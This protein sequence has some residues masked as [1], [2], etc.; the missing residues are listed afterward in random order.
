MGRIFGVN[1]TKWVAR[2]LLIAT[3]LLV[4]TLPFLEDLIESESSADAL[5]QTFQFLFPLLFTL[6]SLW[7]LT[8]LYLQVHGAER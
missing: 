5:Q 7:V 2:V 4:F 8:T 1:A 3:V 6:G